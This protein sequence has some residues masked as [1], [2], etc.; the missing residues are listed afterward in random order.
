MPML[1]R[2]AAL[3][4][5]FIAADRVPYTAHVAP[6]VVRT[7]F[8]DYLQVLRLAGAAFESND[9]GEL[10]NWHERL[11]VLWRNVGTPNVALWAQVIRRRTGLASAAGETALRRS[12][13]RSF[14]NDL[15]TRYQSRL[16]G[17]TLMTNEVYLAVVYRPVPGL[18][19]GLASKLLSRTQRGGSRLALADALDACEK[20]SQT[21]MASLSRYEPDVLGSY[22][23]QD[24]WYSSLLEYLGL[25]INGE[26]QRCPLPN[27][28]LNRALATT[29][30]LF[31][32]ETIE[33]RA[34]TKTRLGAMLG[35]KEYAT[36]SVVGMYSR[37]LS[38]PFAFVMTQSFAFLSKPAAQSLLQR[39]F[40]RMANAGDFAVSQAAQLKDAL[41][42]LTSNEFVMGD[43]H[44]SLQ[45]LADVAES[46]GGAG[47]VDRLKELNDHVALARSLLAD[48]GMLVARE[49][50]ALEASFWAQLPGNFPIRPRKAPITSRNFAAMAPFHNYPMGRAAGN[51]WG[52]AL[53]VL[54]T[55]ANS[56]YYFSLHASDPADPG[57]GSRKDTGHTLICGPTGSGKTVFIGFL[58]AMLDRQG[59]TQVVFDKDRGLEILV[60]A[61]GGEY[62][63]LKSGV[64]TG[65]NPLQLP[66]TP[67][68]VEFLRTWLTELAAGAFPTRRNS[69]VRE[70]AD[71]DQ[72]LRG[73]LS[74]VPEARRLSRLV[75][76]LD[77]TDPE[78]LHARLAR[79]CEVAGV[80]TRGFSTIP[81]TPWYR[82]WTAA[83]SSAST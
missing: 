7:V 3:R 32:S 51:H 82:D 17:E 4:R 46:D 28:P 12:S 66:V 47:D 10:N 39:Q 80:I 9:D 15:H 13:S 75:E 57:G 37:F 67:A 8:G 74:L 81:A 35:I 11:N 76:F 77:P 30:L 6:T 5:E 62:L 26:W 42:A 44:L 19:T 79:W 2:T 56:P 55:S 20:L 58:I 36:P 45:V 64:P 18:G 72:A 21:L 25:L 73:T 23:R 53:C 78:G 71:L 27:G 60:R 40:N 48:T 54:V 41:D 69:A 59:V 68:N 50:L 52:D 16:A 1:K 43:H 38:A 70:A 31:G 14:A 24:I 63:P 29:R 49:D 61:L 22:Q 33:Y 65:F 34:P 83:Q